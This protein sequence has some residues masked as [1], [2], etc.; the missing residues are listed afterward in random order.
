MSDVVSSASGNQISHSAIVQ[1]SVDTTIDRPKNRRVTFTTSKQNI[2]YLELAMDKIVFIKLHDFD[3]AEA[4][5]PNDIIVNE[6]RKKRIK[7]RRD[8]Y[9]AFSSC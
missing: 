9:R 4:L 7:K 5:D 3:I 2:F 6:A 1:I 8:L